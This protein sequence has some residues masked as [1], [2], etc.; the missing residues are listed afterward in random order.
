MAL[1]VFT[2]TYGWYAGLLLALVAMTGALEWLPVVFAPTFAYLV[3]SDHDT[4]DL[5]I[6][7]LLTG[8]VAAVR[9]GDSL[10]RWHRSIS[11]GTGRSRSSPSTPRR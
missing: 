4:L 1:L 10:R 2:P 7:A 6:A 11:R 3:H 9:H 8:A 5:P